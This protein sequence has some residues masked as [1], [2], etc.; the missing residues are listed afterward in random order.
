[1]FRPLPYRSPVLYTPVVVRPFPRGIRNGITSL[2]ELGI[3]AAVKG[4]PVNVAEWS[5]LPSADADD[6]HDTLAF[7]EWGNPGSRRRLDNLRKHYAAGGEHS[8]FVVDD[9]EMS[10]GIVAHLMGGHDTP[11]SRAIIALAKAENAA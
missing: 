9:K 8:P 5:P 3:L 4:T 1:M 6:D 10:A 11:L 7:P 2:V